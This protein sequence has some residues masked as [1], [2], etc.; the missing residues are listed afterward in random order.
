MSPDKPTLSIK[1]H[2]H[3]NVITLCPSTDNVRVSGQVEL[4]LPTKQSVKFIKIKMKNAEEI[5]KYAKR[6]EKMFMH[7]VLT[8]K[9]NESL[10]QGLHK[11]DF[12]FHVSKSQPCFAAGDVAAYIEAKVEFDEIL[13]HPL[14]ANMFIILLG[15]P[16][17]SQQISLEHIHQDF[18]EDVGSFEVSF[19]SK[20][21]TTQGFIDIGLYLPSAAPGL[22]IKGVKV[23]FEQHTVIQNKDKVIS[24]PPVDKE[25]LL[26][27]GSRDSTLIRA[28]SEQDAITGHWILQLPSND[29]IK[30]TTMEFSQGRIQRKHYLEF[31]IMF[32]KDTLRLAAVRVPLTITQRTLSTAAQ[33]PSDYGQ[34][35]NPIPTKRFWELPH[36]HLFS[37][38][39]ADTTEDDL[40]SA[41]VGNAIGAPQGLSLSA[42]RK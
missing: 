40:K 32:K 37:H 8:F 27:E 29:N 13:A 38:C 10:D 41:A 39:P 24:T 26:L 20:H 2:N 34:S 17:D 11:Y 25:V 28:N 35:S 18:V 21:L 36:S 5:V 9:Q 7:E 3:T 31:N 22:E 15:S 30:P 19:K 1:L 6:D 16:S 4:N 14:I 12:D 23:K 42:L 33:V